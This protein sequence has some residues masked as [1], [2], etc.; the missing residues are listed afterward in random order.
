MNFIEQWKKENNLQ[1]WTNDGLYKR[2]ISLKFAQRC[3]Y[4]YRTNDIG[5]KRSMKILKAKRKLIQQELKKRGL[6][7]NTIKR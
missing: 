6:S 1:K 5:Y 3:S 4:N 7:I 2:L